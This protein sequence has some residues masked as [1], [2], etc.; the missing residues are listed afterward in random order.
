V[1][2]AT[3]GTTTDAVVVDYELAAAPDVVWRALTESDLLARWLMANDFEPTVGHKFTFQANPAPN[4]DGIVH[5]EV[6]EVDEPHR[7]AYAW[8]GGAGE[9]A[10]DTVVTWTLTPD[11][12]GGTLLHLE[13]AGFL[14]KNAM[15]REGMGRGWRG[16]IAERLRELTESLR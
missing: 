8:R 9:Y 11:G 13:H 15:G 4:W 12:S 1:S 7:L 6:L 16:P 10:L 14:P 2:D 5:C 3:T